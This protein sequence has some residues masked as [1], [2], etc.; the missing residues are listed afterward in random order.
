M[1]E[2]IVHVGIMS[3][4]I[5]EFSLNGR[6]RINGVQNECTGNQCVTIDNERIC[7]NNGSYESIQFS[8]Q[9]S[10]CSFTLYNVTIGVNFHWEQKEN[11]SFNGILRFIVDNHSITAINDIE[12]EKYL[13]SVISSEM[14]ATSSLELLK[15]HAVIS[16]SWLMAQ[17]Q[18][19]QK[20]DCSE[21][22]LKTEDELIKWY[23][24]K[25]H[26]N[27]DVCADDHCQRYQGISK[28][29]TTDV[30]KAIDATK[31][32]ILTYEGKICD[33][34]FSK[35][36]GGVSELFE[37]CWEPDHHNYLEKVIDSK[38]LTAIED[39]SIE[40]N[41]RKWI[42]ETKM[43]SFCNT[44]DQRV[45]RQVLNNFD[46]KTND[47]FRWT[48]IY[49]QMTLSHLIAQKTNIE[50][51]NIIDLVPMKRGVSGRIIKLKIVGQKKTFIIG[52]E[53]EIR[54]TLSES[55]LY[56]SAFVVDKIYS[57]NSSIPT[58]FIF[59]GAGWGHGVGLCQIGAAVMADKGYDYLDILQHYFH[60]ANLSPNYGK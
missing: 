40:E 16:R 37:N 35:S 42:L 7:F 12:V 48:V 13:S 59:H 20:K 23:D 8:P 36:C 18:N 30:A 14:S 50:F 38:K 57:N 53:L 25:D 49:D 43:D 11:Q 28:E 15:A 6:F 2:P 47:F 3:G 52:K 60:N 29:T 58:S 46:Q 27:F 34:R 1:N 44:Q 45:L 41:A 51:G 21:F 32:E 22:Q 19:T 54:K 4:K 9:D 33:T 39:L 26:T 56:S 24:H 17:I 55:H 31:G 5:I 10:N